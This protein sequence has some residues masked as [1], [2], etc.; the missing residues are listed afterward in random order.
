[1]AC[2]REGWDSANSLFNF[3][4]A[5]EIVYRCSTEKLFDLINGEKKT[6]KTSGT[7]QSVARVKQQVT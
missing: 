7:D 3:L 1:L 6:G 4:K 2:N 5:L